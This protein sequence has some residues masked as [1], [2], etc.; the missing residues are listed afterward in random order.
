M[1]LTLINVNVTLHKKHKTLELKNPN[2][3]EIDDAVS[4]IWMRFE[5][6]VKR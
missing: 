1:I 4:S 2:M 5:M 3:D 6:M